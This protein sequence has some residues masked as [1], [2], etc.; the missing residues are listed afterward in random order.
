M[1]GIDASGLLRVPDQTPNKGKNLDHLRRTNLSLVLGLV[2]RHGQLSR[3]ELTR[4]LGLNRSTIAALVSEL[5][6]RGLVIE[7][8][9]ESTKQV[10]RPSLVIT[11]NPAIT[12]ITV[13]P[14]VDAMTIGVVTLGG[15][16]LRRIR[17]DNVRLP[18]A[19]EVVN[20]VTAIVE[21]MTASS[22]GGYQILGV[23]MA[24]PGLVRASDGMVGLAPHLAWRD[25]PV[26]RRLAESTGYEVFA[27]NDATCG[28]IAEYTFGAGRGATDMIFLN[29][30]ASGIGGGI[31]VDGA[32]LSGVHGFAGE[33][34]HTLVNSAGSEC[35]CGSSGCL[36]TEVRRAP[37]LELLGL[38]DPSSHLLDERLHDH[39]STAPADDPVRVEVTRQAGYLLVALRN[40]VNTFNT[41]R[42]VL[43]GF[44]GALHSA[45][46][47]VFAR[48]IGSG[49]MIGAEGGV[50][51]VA[52][53]LGRNAPLV[54]AAELVF[55]PLL[56]NPSSIGAAERRSSEVPDLSRSRHVPPVRG[57]AEA[58]PSLRRIVGV[59]ATA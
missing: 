27:A 30:G 21:G 26:S 22:A 4:E 36:E 16:V 57:Q 18:S 39:L 55:G 6:D 28:A 13:K 2:H 37:L 46:P 7:S 53:E 1:P 54:G 19:R 31:I 56:A 25:E 17:Y 47:E 32:L 52:A 34:G 15:R 41:R 42:I 20:V 8:L 3:A 10:G 44:L 23:G 33:L 49:A 29:G 45:C 9:P 51:V 11:T 50:E 40:A 58:D 24:V 5:V 48:L 59:A 35:H 43:G 38:D 12:A 14:D